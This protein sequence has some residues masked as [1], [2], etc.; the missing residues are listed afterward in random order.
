MEP[1][2]QSARNRH[3]TMTRDFHTPPAKYLPVVGPTADLVA[4]AT[5][6]AKP[7]PLIR[8]RS[9]GASG[10]SLN[11]VAL[12][13]PPLKSG[14]P[15]LGFSLN[16]SELIFPVRLCAC[17]STVTV[18]ALLALRGCQV[19]VQFPSCRLINGSGKSPLS[20]EARTVPFVT[21]I[22]QSSTTFTISATGNPNPP[23]WSFCRDRHTVFAT[24]KTTGYELSSA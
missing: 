7:L 21:P 5:P 19:T 23:R 1:R 15:A 14:G 11:V 18:T 17:A 20:K 9:P 13:A 10:P 8:T 12:T 3:T 6:S 24:S 2:R 4:L 16:A 22:P